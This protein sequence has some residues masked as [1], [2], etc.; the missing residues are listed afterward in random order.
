[1]TEGR[2]IFDKLIMIFEGRERM[3][4]QSLESYIASGDLPLIEAIEKIDRNARGILYIVD[5]DEH[6]V[7]SITDGDIRRWILKGG[8]L[9]AKI[10]P[11]VFKD[12]VVSHTEDIRKNLDLMFIKSIHSIP[13]V[14]ENGRIIDIQFEPKLQDELAGKSSILR[15]M[16]II[17]MAGGAGTRLHP[18]T[19]IL[20]KPLIPIGEIPILERIIDRFHIYGADRFI[21]TVNYKKE[22]IKSYFNGISRDYTVDF[23]EENEPLGTAGSISLIDKELSKT[24]VVTNCD[25]LI[26]TDYDKLCEYHKESGNA[27][28]IVSSSKRITVPYGV[29]H[30]G[31][32][33]A[34]ESIEEKPSF[35]CLINT[36]LYLI[37]SDLLKRIPTDTV[38]HM[39]D[40]LSA[41]M[42]SGEKVGMYPIS[43]NSFL[44]MGEFEELQRMED[45]INA[46]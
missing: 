45:R 23:I 36:G 35:S 3:N 19:K 39:T 38:F 40:L 2:Y 17:I 43:E 11:I 22:M 10:E 21:I 7:G 31:E 12:T 4:S 30:T 18:Y 32:G 5:D 29:L 46:K 13:I 16:D 26:E 9:Q 15:D 28:T 41:V 20:P 33:G 34:L 14:D 1:M 25:I 6:L 44:D 37:R 24:V 42:E 8:D 27:I